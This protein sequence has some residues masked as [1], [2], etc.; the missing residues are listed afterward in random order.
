MCQFKAVKDL[1]NW[2]QDDFIHWLL[3]GRQKTYHKTK[4]V[5]SVT[6]IYI[7]YL[8]HQTSTVVIFK[9]LM[10]STQL[11]GLSRTSHCQYGKSNKYVKFNL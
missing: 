8:I 10:K 7:T 6:A 9:A 5:G 3:V 4:Y 11:S 2:L 1:E